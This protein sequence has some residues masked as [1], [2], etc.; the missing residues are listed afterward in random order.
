MQKIA[1]LRNSLFYLFIATLLFSIAWYIYAYVFSKSGATGLRVFFTLLTLSI[2]CLSLFCCLHLYETAYNLLS[3]AGI[4]LIS[5]TMVLTLF[6]I[7]YNA[8][9]FASNWKMVEVSIALSVLIAV[10]S[11][12]LKWMSSRE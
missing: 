5:C 11:A 12:V 2:G 4:F 9:F 7:W 3:I 8:S 6:A 10:I 1:I